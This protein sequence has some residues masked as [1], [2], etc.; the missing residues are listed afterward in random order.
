MKRI[1]HVFVC[2]LVVAAAA[3]FRG[4]QGIGRAQAGAHESG[5]CLV[6]VPPRLEPAPG[7]THR[8]RARARAPPH[9]GINESDLNEEGGPLADIRFEYDSA[10]LTTARAGDAARTRGLA[11][12]QPARER[13]HRG[14]LRRARYRG[15]QPGS[16]RTAGA[17]R[18]RVPGRPG[19]AAGRLRTVSFGNERPLDT[20]H[21]EDSWAKNRR[22]HFSVSGSN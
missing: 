14:P 22:D 6:L 4:L 9:D 20:G 19:I 2:A 3:L 8:Q 15:I 7:R 17:R 5:R 16:R 10:A 1:F 21:G 18:G 12:L 11:H 13:H